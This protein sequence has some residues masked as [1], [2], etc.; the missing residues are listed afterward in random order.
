MVLDSNRRDPGKALLLRLHYISGLN[1]DEIAVLMATCS[2]D[3]ELEQT[4]SELANELIAR[5]LSPEVL[6][7]QN[8]RP[9]GDVTLFL[10]K[11]RDGERPLGEVVANEGARLRRQAEHLLRL[12]GGNISLQADD[13]VNEL[14][15]RMPKAPEKSPRN[16]L[17]FDTLAKRIMRHILIDRARKPIPSQSKFSGEMSN[18]LSTSPIVDESLLQEEVMR[19]VYQV[20]AEMRQTDRETAGMLKAALFGGA[21]QKEIAKLYAVSV[22]T[23]KRRIKDARDKIRERLGLE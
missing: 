4:A 6:S 8:L 23:V 20:L 16:H 10:E 1:W 2:Q 7:E 21:D 5:G 11:V 12:E 17:E 3:V 22:S 18:D 19:V 14:F 9:R 13:L 15:L